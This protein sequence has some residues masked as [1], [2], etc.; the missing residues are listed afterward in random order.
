MIKGEDVNKLKEVINRYFK[1]YDVRWEYDSAAFFCELDETTLEKDFNSLRRDLII[2]GYIPMVLHEGGEH[3]IYV[4]ERAVAKYKSVKVNLILLLA[5]MCTTIFVGAI[6]WWS[7]DSKHLDPNN[8]WDIL[9]PTALGNG[10]LY[11]AFPLMLILGIHELGHYFMAK[12][13]G[14]AASL[15]F[16][17]PVPVPPLGTFGAFISMREPI[18]DKKALLDIGVAGPIC[19]FCVAVPVIILGFKLTDIF[20]MPVPQDAG[21]LVYMGTSLF[22]NLLSSAFPT[23]NYLTHP[24]ALAGWVG[25]LVTFLNLLPAGQLDGGH[26]ARALFGSW[27]KYLSYAA[28]IIMLVLSFYYQYFGWILFIFIIVFIGVSHPPPLNDITPLDGKRYLTGA[29]VFM[30]LIGCFTPVPLYPAQINH[31]G[32]LLLPI[33]SI[34]IAPNGTAQL[35][36]MVNDTGN[37]AQSYSLRLVPGPKAGLAG[38]NVSFNSTKTLL[39]LTP[40][41][42][43]GKQKEFTIYVKSPLNVTVGDK[44]S[45][46]VTLSWKDDSNKRHVRTALVTIV[47]GLV[48]I[49]PG[50]VKIEMRP[51]LSGQNNMTVQYLGQGNMIVHAEADLPTGWHIEF[52]QEGFEF[53]ELSGNTANSWYRL[54]VPPG[55]PL[56]T[57]NITLRVVAQWTERVQSGGNWTN[58]TVR[59]SNNA[60]VKVVVLQAFAVG[61]SVD[62]Q[63]LTVHYGSKA[64]VNVTVANHGNGPDQIN[65]TISSVTN[66]SVTPSSKKI[67][68]GQGGSFWFDLTIEPLANRS[69]DMNILVLAQSDGD[70]SAMV[71]RTI[72]VRVET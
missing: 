71:T 3:I 20:A 4:Q 66:L 67:V 31:N 50:A 59:S 47:V 21:G 45:L 34:N 37:V 15:P 41:V 56:N 6:N 29:V 10:A 26:V 60:T 61:L 14:V 53:T 11:F 49:A 19:G 65:L 40:T 55:E 24:T 39:R 35:S 64:V 8:M 68:L 70:R 23:G 52:G 58:L 16:F 17:I 43:P 69:T 72:E 12:H 33:N 5:T 57:R 22:Y 2:R 54:E 28:I 25:L 7:Y 1:V 51:G 9:T 36:A 32:R 30:I 27:S 62:K 42:Q 63:M 48:R 38:W 44:T 13:H 46:N 18:P